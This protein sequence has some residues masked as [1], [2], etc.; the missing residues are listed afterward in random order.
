MGIVTRNRHRVLPKAIESALR[1]TYPRVRVAVLD[2]GSDD[3]TPQ[4]RS[5][6]PTVRWIRWEQSRGY[7]EGR[8]YLM[9]ESNADFYLSLDD[10]AWFISDDEISIAVQ[11]LEANPKVA[12]AAFDI[13]SP[14]RKRRDPRSEPL[15]THQFVGC[16]HMLRT[17]AVR[18][19]GFYVPFP[20]YYGSEEMDLSIRLLDRNWE[21]HFLRGVH[22]WH[23]KTTIARDILAQ[24]RSGVCNDLAFAARRC[25]FPLVLGIIPVKLMNHV[26]FAAKNHLLKPCLAGLQLFISRALLVLN[27][28]EPVRASTFVEF[29]RRSHKTL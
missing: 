8:N 16:G 28:R 10:D 6:Y 7:L 29:I 2:D 22:V 9:R 15:A 5:R 25:P 24:H 12:A 13:L 4:L 23:D 27:S 3:D 19:C 14:D 11:D 20:G 21:I 18:E 1:Q 17:S 26:R